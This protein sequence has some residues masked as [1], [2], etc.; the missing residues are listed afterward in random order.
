M[1]TCVDYAIDVVSKDRL[2]CYR[3]RSPSFTLRQDSNK[4]FSKHEKHLLKR[5]E[6]KVELFSYQ[7]LHSELNERFLSLLLRNSSSL[8][9][10]PPTMTMRSFSSSSEKWRNATISLEI[11]RSLHCSSSQVV[12]VQHKRM[13]TSTKRV[14]LS[15]VTDFIATAGFITLSNKTFAIKFHSL[16]RS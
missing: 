8:Q 11:N 12:I 5:I 16:K 4:S 6:P 3:N 1:V 9:L 15:N 7:R 2:S 13:T 10:Q 14:L